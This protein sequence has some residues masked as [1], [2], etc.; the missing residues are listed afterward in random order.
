MFDTYFIAT[1]I[2]DRVCICKIDDYIDAWHE[3]KAGIGK[4]LYE[5]LGMTPIEYAMWVERPEILQFIIDAHLLGKPI[6]EVIHDAE[7]QATNNAQEA[8]QIHD[9]LIATHRLAA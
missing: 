9:W 5:F 3:G 6:Q 1:C 4:E 2:K 8:I 7:H